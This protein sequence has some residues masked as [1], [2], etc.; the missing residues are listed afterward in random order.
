[1]TSSNLVD[2]MTAGRPGGVAR[3]HHRSPTMALQPAGQDPERSSRP[4]R[5]QY[6]S[7]R[8]RTPVFLDNVIAGFGR[9]IME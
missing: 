1:M 4:E 9:R 7:V 6:R 8:A 2:C 3:R 5:S